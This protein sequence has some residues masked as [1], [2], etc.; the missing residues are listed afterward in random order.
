MTVK[1]VSI[2]GCKEY[3]QSDFDIDHL[4][5]YTHRVLVFPTTLGHLWMESCL[6]VVLS[7]ISTGPVRTLSGALPD[8]LL[9]GKLTPPRQDN[10]PSSPD[11]EPTKGLCSDLCEWSQDG[12]ALSVW[13][14]L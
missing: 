6:P 1:S 5:M 12:V 3:N 4:V 2:F 13:A 10:P 11:T 7:T 9:S 14:H 8:R